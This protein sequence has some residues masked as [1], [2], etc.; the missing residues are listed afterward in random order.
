MTA[1]GK[2][3]EDNPLAWL[4]YGPCKKDWTENIHIES[5]QHV[6]GEYTHRQV[7]E[8]LVPTSNIAEALAIAQQLNLIQPGPQG[9]LL[10][11]SKQLAEQKE[12]GDT[13]DVIDV[14]HS[15]GNGKP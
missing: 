1:E 5:E 2:V 15:N 4:R 11:Q 13:T 6:Q 12:E 10:F 9:L 8:E 3:K 14:P 7:M